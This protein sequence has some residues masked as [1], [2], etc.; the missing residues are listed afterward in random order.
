[1]CTLRRSKALRIHTESSKYPQWGIGQRVISRDACCFRNIIPSGLLKAQLFALLAFYCLG[2][3]S[4]RAA[5]HQV[6][7]CRF[8]LEHSSAYIGIFQTWSTKVE[9]AAVDKTDKDCTFQD[10]HFNHS[11]LLNTAR[12]HGFR[13]AKLLQDVAEM[14]QRNSAS[15][16]EDSSLSSG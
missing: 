6:P 13:P 8:A 9:S 12:Q 4:P 2:A 16:W 3:R 11:M 1:M 10:F 14:F 7:N 15:I 5:L